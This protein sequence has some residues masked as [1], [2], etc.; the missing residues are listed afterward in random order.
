MKNSLH[1]IMIFMTDSML[2]THRDRVLSSPR[3]MYLMKWKGHPLSNCTWIIDEELLALDYDLY[4]KFHAFNSL[5]SSSFKPGRD[6]GG[7]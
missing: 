7:P 3:E 6:D 1:L 5:G 2:L 4:D